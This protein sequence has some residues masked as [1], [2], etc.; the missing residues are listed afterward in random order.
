MSI[1]EEGAVYR[2]PNA[3]LETVLYCPDLDAAR[4]SYEDV[5]GFELV[6]SEPGRHCFFRVGKQMLLLFQPDV[7]SQSQVRV[8]P[9]VIPQHGSRGPGHIAFELHGNQSE[10]T[11]RHLRQ[12][13]CFIESEIQWPGGGSSIYIR[14]PAGNSVEFA[15]RELWFD[16][17]DSS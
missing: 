15:T 11:R 12:H 2:P 17:E 4:S 6:S 3:I 10:A 8:G 13:D 5:L 9:A 16:S 14:D 1:Y 7:T